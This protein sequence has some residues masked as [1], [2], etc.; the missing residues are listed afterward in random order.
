MQHTEARLE[1]AHWSALHNW[2]Y[3]NSNNDYYYHHWSIQVIYTNTCTQTH[4]DMQWNQWWPW[5]TCSEISKDHDRHV[6]TPTSKV[7]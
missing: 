5:H 6:H 3:C 2:H 1:L 4:T 7:R